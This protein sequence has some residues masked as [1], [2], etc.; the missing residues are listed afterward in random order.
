M[1]NKIPEKNSV[2]YSIVELNNKWN[3]VEVAFD[4]NALEA[5]ETKIV[6]THS[7][8]MEIEHQFKV[9]TAERLFR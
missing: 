9:K 8:Y 2:A 1:E 3:L 6:A 4:K 5:V 7:D